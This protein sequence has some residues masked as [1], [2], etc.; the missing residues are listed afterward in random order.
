MGALTEGGKCARMKVRE[1]FEALRQG[2]KDKWDWKRWD[3][4]ETRK[5]GKT[6]Q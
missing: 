2:R 3:K 5:A 4:L 6:N 1:W